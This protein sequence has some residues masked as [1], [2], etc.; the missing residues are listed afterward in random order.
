M[1]LFDIKHLGAITIDQNNRRFQIKCPIGGAGS[2]ALQAMLGLSSITDTISTGMS[3][4]G[5]MKWHD[6]D[7]LISYRRVIDNERKT[8]GNH[9]NVRIVKGLW[10]GGGGKTSKNVTTSAS[11]VIKLDSLDTP[12]ITVPIMNKPLSGAAYDKAMKYMEDTAAALDWI[13]R[14]R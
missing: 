14:H 13:V 5:V 6:F 11:I 4:A 1:G 3:I 7:E 10:A 9:A 8:V 12:V 2:Q